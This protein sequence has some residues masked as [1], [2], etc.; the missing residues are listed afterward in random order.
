MIYAEIP[1]AKAQQE[2][3][4]AIKEA[5][6]KRWYVRLM[7]IAL[8][9]QRDTVIKL[10][11]MFSVCRSTVRSY[12]HSYNEGGLEGLKPVTQSGRPAK[13]AHWTKET[14]LH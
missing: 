13:L 10:S 4:D 5:K 11:E 2:L 1:D 14:C 7:I 12:I 6:V 8:S 9:A 3:D